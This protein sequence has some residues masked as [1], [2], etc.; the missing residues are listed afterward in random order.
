[1]EGVRVIVTDEGDRLA[2]STGLFQNQLMS[3][4][5]NNASALRSRLEKYVN[6]APDPNVIV[7]EG[8]E[9][10]TFFT[11][12]L[13]ETARFYV[14]VLGF[15]ALSV[16]PV[17]DPPDT[18][19]IFFAVGGGATLVF[20]DFPC[21]DPLERDREGT[22]HHVAI[23]VSEARLSDLVSRMVAHGVQYTGPIRKEY[24]SL[25]VRDPS[26]VFLEFLTGTRL[27]AQ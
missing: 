27:V 4:R 25:Y 5:S 14:E 13:E 21:A 23:R 18:T 8:I 12:V 2:S 22:L 1:M 17:A 7:G 10:L 11:A 24:T 20:S 3:E 26:G 6:R 9:H 16:E 15:R 19:Q